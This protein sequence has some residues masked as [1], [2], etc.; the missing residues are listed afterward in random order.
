MQAAHG[1]AAA[2]VVAGGF[3]AADGGATKGTTETADG[4]AETTSSGG[5]YC[6]ARLPDNGTLVTTGSATTS[7]GL[8]HALTTT[9]ATTTANNPPERAAHGRLAPVRCRAA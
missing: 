4:L 8:A 1:T 5:T 9:V 2:F 7:A 3:G 6:G